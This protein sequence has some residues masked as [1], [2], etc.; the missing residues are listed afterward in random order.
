MKATERPMKRAAPGRVPSADQA[1]A[2][3]TAAVD[4]AWLLHGQ[5][6]R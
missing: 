4:F 1:M 2:F 6:R 5:V 3:S